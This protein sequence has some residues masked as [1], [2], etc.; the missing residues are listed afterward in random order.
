MLDISG[1]VAPPKPVRLAEYRPPDFV[2]DTVDLTFELRDA[3]TGVKSRLG[4]RR[5]PEAPDRKA[6]LHLDGEELEL[7][8]IA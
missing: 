3:G 1:D 6:P 4:I 7:L 5:N 8:S 2:I